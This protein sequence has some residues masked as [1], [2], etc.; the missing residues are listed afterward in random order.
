[1]GHWHGEDYVK[2][3]GDQTCLA[4]RSMARMKEKEVRNVCS[5]SQTQ[6]H[7]LEIACL[8][9]PPSFIYVPELSLCASSA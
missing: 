6:L 5:V 4:T 2:M 1:M 8:K 7:L 9:F 3:P